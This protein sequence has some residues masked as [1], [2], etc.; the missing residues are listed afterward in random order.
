MTSNAKQQSEFW[1]DQYDTK[2]ALWGKDPSV[3]VKILWDA[4][5]QLHENSFD[6]RK[7][8]TVGAGYYRD[9]TYLASR[10]VSVDGYEISKKGRDLG[11]Q[12]ARDK[13]VFNKIKFIAKDFAKAVLKGQKFDAVFS[14]RTLHLLDND[15]VKSFVKNAHDA[16]DENGLLV[17]SARDDR[18]FNEDQMKWI[19]KD[20]GIAEYTLKGKEGHKIQFWNMARFEKYFGE[21]FE[22]DV[23]TKKS[24]EESFGNNDTDGNPI[25]AHVTVMVAYSKA[26]SKQQNHS[27]NIVRRTAET[28]ADSLVIS[29]ASCFALSST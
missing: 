29:G 13:T 24:E 17:V 2:G 12:F 28:I 26:T 10:G 11:R 21:S 5:Q 18:D 9:E 6:V 25:Q 7:V 22:I 27:P 15:Q 3:A 1:D 23:I 8:L 4:L 20:A 19:D 14:H 16:L